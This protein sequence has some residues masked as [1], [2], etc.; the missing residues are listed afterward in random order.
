LKFRVRILG[1][2]DKLPG[3]YEFSKLAYRTFI[4]PTGSDK[5]A[6]PTPAIMVTDRQLRHIISKYRQ[7][8]EPST[9]D[10]VRDKDFYIPKNR[11]LIKT[12]DSVGEAEMI[13]M[14]NSLMNYAGDLNLFAFNTEDF[15]TR[16]SRSLALMDIFSLVIQ[17][18]AFTLCFFQI[19]VAVNTNM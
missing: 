2:V 11:I 13:T 16:I 18:F 3:V 7:V 19:I 14:R 4:S 12:A 17:V 15:I 8:N 1:Y 5:Q 6:W 9:F 10:E